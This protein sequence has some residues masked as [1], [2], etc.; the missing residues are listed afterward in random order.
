MKKLLVIG[1]FC[2]ALAAIGAEPATDKALETAALD[3][4]KRLESAGRELTEVRARIAAE[5][6]PLA[7]K[8]SE[9]EERVVAV[10]A[11]SARLLS[12][13]SQ[14][15]NL[16]ARRQRDNEKIAGSLS[17]ISNLAQESLKV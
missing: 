2:S 5:R 4:G 1:L 13:D 7:Q 10:V 3:Y 9:L 15:A 11:E 17:Y 12:A 14:A 16:R 8:L 6:A